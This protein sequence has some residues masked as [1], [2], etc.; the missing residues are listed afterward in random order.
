MT[1]VEIDDARASYRQA[2]ERAKS[3]RGFDVTRCEWLSRHLKDA[4]DAMNVGDTDG[5][6]Q[7][8][9]Q[10]RVG[11]DGVIRKFLINSVNSFFAPRFD[12]A[13]ARFMGEID[14]LVANYPEWESD[15]TYVQVANFWNKR[16]ASLKAP[17]QFEGNLNAWIEAY[18]KAHEALDSLDD[19]FSEILQGRRTRASFCKRKA[20]ELRVQ[21]A[22]EQRRQRKAIRQRTRNEKLSDP[23]VQKTI[24]TDYA[25]LLAEVGIKPKAIKADDVMS[26]TNN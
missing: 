6:I 3:V 23:E 9:N 7:A 24:D 14:I 22:Q 5:A 26:A 21:Q 2:L 20:T 12:K 17:T 25:E 13:V 11:L 4:A 16:L 10:A 1:Q 15:R 18:H 8:F 19:Q